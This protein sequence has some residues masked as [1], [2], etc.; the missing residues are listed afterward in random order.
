MNVVVVLR[1]GVEDEYAAE[2]HEIKYISLGP[3]P[4]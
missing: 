4:L 2:G 3:L 1:A